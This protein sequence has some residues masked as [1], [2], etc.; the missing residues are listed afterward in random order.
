MLQEE[1][2]RWKTKAEEAEDRRINDVRETKEKCDALIKKE[3][4]VTRR[5]FAEK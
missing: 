4:E 1:I 5:E 3:H 2:D